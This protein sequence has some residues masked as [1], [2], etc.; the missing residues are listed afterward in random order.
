MKVD[1]FYAFSAEPSK[2]QSRNVLLGDTLTG[3]RAQY[4][5]QWLG[6]RLIQQSILFEDNPDSTKIKERF[7]YEHD[8]APVAQ[9]EIPTSAPSR[10][11]SSAAPTAE[12]SIES[13]SG[14]TEAAAIP[15]QQ[16]V[17]EPM[18]AESGEN[19]PSASTMIHS[20]VE[21][22][23]S[24]TNGE[25]MSSVN[26]AVGTESASTMAQPASSQDVEMS[27]AQ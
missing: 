27:N 20:S 24:N 3:S 10:S 8:A 2:P 1:V 6:E 21:Q 26:G 4:P 13:L 17:N 25:S 23:A 19:A 22:E 11:L 14:M 9:S 5:L 7:V 15:P 12:P 18:V 16:P